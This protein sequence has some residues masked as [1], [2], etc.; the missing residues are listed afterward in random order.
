MATFPINNAP[1]SLDMDIV[2]AIS[3]DLG[4]L[5]KSCRY[6]V[7]ITPPQGV[8]GTGGI[9]SAIGGNNVDYTGLSQDLTYLC[10]A[11]EFPG[12]GFENLEIRYYGPTFKV[13]HRSEYEPINMTFICRNAGAEREF[14][15]DWMN[16]INPVD[17][18]NFN[19]RDSYATNLRLFSF[20][21]EFI[22]TYSFTLIDCFPILINPQPVTWADDNFMR[23]TVNFTYTKWIREGKDYNGYYIDS[24]AL[25]Y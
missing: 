25:G 7:S 6:A 9:N 17:T 15:D 20:D 21:E 24:N 13:P 12:R 4:G 23:L 5:A 2:W 1:F 3:E 11:T 18:F 22:P 10:E 8:L 19:Y 16:L 14:F